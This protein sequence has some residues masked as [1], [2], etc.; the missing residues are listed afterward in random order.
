MRK[1][2]IIVSFLLMSIF[3]FA[4]ITD[5]LKLFKKEEITAIEQKIGEISDKRKVTIYVNSFS[6]EEGFVV[7][8][9]EKLIIL[10]L[11]KKSEN[12]YKVEL[13]L[14]KDMELDEFRENIDEILTINEKYLKEK[15]V[16]E[17][18]VETLVGLDGVLENIKIEEPIVVEEDIVTEKKNGFFIGMGIAFFV[19]FAIILR[20]LMLK[21]RKSF[22]EEMD[23]ISRKKY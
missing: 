11:I 13:K 9:A 17:Y 5:D 12:N 4:K 16:G 3:S 19:I 8:K 15:K 23:I 10:N 18:V 7:E 22:R 20:V 2:L 14:T 1:K 21:Y 6:E